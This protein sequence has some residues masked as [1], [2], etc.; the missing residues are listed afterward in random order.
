M[1]KRSS[2]LKNI[3]DILTGFG[4]GVSRF[5]LSGLGESGGELAFAI[6]LPEFFSMKMALSEFVRQSEILIA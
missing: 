5:D 3:A 2:Q 1:H 6:S 4:F